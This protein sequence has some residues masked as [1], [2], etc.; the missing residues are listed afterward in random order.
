MSGSRTVL[1]SRKS[2]ILTKIIKRPAAEVEPVLD[3]QET[4]FN[5]RQYR[6]WDD[7]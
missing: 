5:G 1:L 7:E 2:P 4:S 6:D 3:K